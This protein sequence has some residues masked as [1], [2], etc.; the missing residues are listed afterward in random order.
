MSLTQYHRIGSRV[1][2]QALANLLL[3]SLHAAE[4]AIPDLQQ[5]G[6]RDL[7]LEWETP[8]G[9][10]RVA[11]RGP[12]H[13]TGEFLLL[14]DLGGDD[15]YR[16][17]GR[18]LQPNQISTVIDLA[19]DDTV[20]WE[21][22]P[23]PGAGVMG[24]GL[25]IDLSGDDRYAGRNL[26]MGAGVFGA[27]LL[28]DAEGDDV[29]EGGSRVQGAGQYGVG[30][31][32]D[33]GGDDT[34]TAQLNSQG[35]G[36]TGGFGLLVDL[37]G[38]DSYS[39][40]PLVPDDIEERIQ[41]HD[42][43]H[44]T[45]FCQGSAFGRRPAVSGGIG[46]LLDRKGNDRYAVD[47]FG[48]GSALWFG[49]GMLVDG[50]GHDRYQAFEHGQGDGVHLGAG[51]LS[52]WG[53][54]DEYTGYEHCQGVGVDRAA[55]LL[56]DDSGDDLYRSHSESQGAGVKPYGVGLLIDALGDDRYQ[57]A[58]TSQGY[59]ARPP[60][61]FPESEWPVGVLLDLGGADGFVQPEIPQPDPR[62]RK[63]NRQGIAVDQ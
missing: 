21:Q 46:L 27:G 5:L 11:G 43:P 16:E 14:I 23:G 58:N 2:T 31:L 60:D 33:G 47:L 41:R 61:G 38:N 32:L 1:D 6:D 3:N 4:L 10:V 59:S 51:L 53:G 54:D 30:V 35:Y 39:C 37:A 55:G 22:T 52:D 19:G 63:Q 57:A 8:L 12:D 29:Y 36:G 15:I 28:W 18:A 26:S 40:T 24:I 17:V 42:A 62:G 48:Q 13:H 9:R 7:P 56:Y 25:W 44:Y 45:N 20:L 34:Y 50:A 49:L